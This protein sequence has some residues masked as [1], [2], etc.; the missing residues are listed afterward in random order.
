MLPTTSKGAD[1]RQGN[2][3]QTTNQ[4][5]HLC[6][7]KYQISEHCLLHL[8][9]LTSARMVNSGKYGVGASDLSREGQFDNHSVHEIVTDYRNSSDFRPFL[10]KNPQT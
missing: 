2:G 3:K 6:I 9:S 1:S 10:K 5:K 4:N 8:I 7:R